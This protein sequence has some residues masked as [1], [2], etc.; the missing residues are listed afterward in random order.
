MP[1]FSWLYCHM[2]SGS[3][4]SI[5]DII[6]NNF[7][8]FS[9]GGSNAGKNTQYIRWWHVGKKTVQLT[10][11]NVGQYGLYIKANVLRQIGICNKVAPGRPGG[12][13]TRSCQ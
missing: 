7:E 2:S 4:L 5:W 11:W 3:F 6:I 10:K 13:M 8:R 9:K 12:R 1:L